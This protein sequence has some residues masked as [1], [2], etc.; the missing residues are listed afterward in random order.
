VNDLVQITSEKYQEL[1]D[2][3]CEICSHCGVLRMRPE[4]EDE[5]Q[6]YATALVLQTELRNLRN[7]FN[8]LKTAVDKVLDDH[9]D[10]IRN[11]EFRIWLAIGGGAVVG[12]L[13]SVALRAFIK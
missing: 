1:D 10:R 5:E 4:S 3:I 12:W 7:S 6:G 13:G 11:I 8:G 2:A 9:E